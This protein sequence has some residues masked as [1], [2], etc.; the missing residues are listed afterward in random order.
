MKRSWSQ[1]LFL[2]INARVGE[3]PFL[4]RFMRFAASWLIYILI[5][6][7]VFWNLIFLYPTSLVR[8]YSYLGT[9]S[10]AFVIGIGVSAL[11]GV[12]FPRRRPHDVMP[13]SRELLHLLP[14]E[15][16]KSFPSDHTMAAFVLVFIAMAFG[17]QALAAIFFLVVAGVI[18][19]SRVYVGVHFPRDIVG[20]LFLALLVALGA[21][22]LFVVCTTWL[23]RMVH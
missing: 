17:L 13:G 19:V 21:T 1:Q 7:L 6:A 12:L 16:W 23:G 14:F 18:A 20:G 2:Q 22:P 15:Y 8:W 9:S 4:D 5:L 11:V 10:L 3:S